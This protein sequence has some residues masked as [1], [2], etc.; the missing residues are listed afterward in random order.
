MLLLAS[1]VD[2][3]WQQ[4][5]G[6]RQLKL[7]YG[8]WDSGPLSIYQPSLTYKSSHT[9]CYRYPSSIF[10]GQMDVA[11][12]LLLTWLGIAY[13]LLLTWPGRQSHIWNGEPVTKR[14]YLT[15]WDWESVAQTWERLAPLRCCFA[16]LCGHFISLCNYFSLICGHFADICGHFLSD[17]VCL[18]FLFLFC[19][20]GL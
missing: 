4:C 11:Y 7:S 18:S 6:K 14:Q 2:C 9:W 13:L 5:P 8:L 17:S 15:S 12:L 19:F 3:R 10:S 16:F 1:A 20:Q